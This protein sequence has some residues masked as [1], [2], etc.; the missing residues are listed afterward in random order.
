M[1]ELPEVEVIRQGL[2]PHVV[3]RQ[4]VAVACSSKK[5]RLAIPQKD[6]GRWLKGGRIT[7]IQRRGKYLIFLLES[8]AAMIVHLGMT[9]RLGIFPATAPP[10]LHDH[11]VF[12]LPEGM[13]LRYNDIRRFGLIRVL[14]PDQYREHD[15]FRD[16]GCEPLEQEF[17]GVYLKKMAAGRL[18]PVKNFLMDNQVVAG[19][20]NIYANEILFHAGILPATPIGS[21]TLARWEKVAEKT[22]EVLLRAIACGGSSISDFVNSSG[23][24]GY[25]QL[26][27]MVYGRAGEAC[28]QC[29]AT[30]GRQVI[31]GRSTFFCPNCQK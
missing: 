24:K 20:G 9:G 1:P 26:E 13:Q 10:A 2:I 3:G 7:A 11:V 28:R 8:G 15:P 6:L 21:L 4:I 16:M 22:R 5:L 17:T 27:L 14:S 18:Q 30:I 31:G 29:A 23:Q 12:S 25:F 19:I